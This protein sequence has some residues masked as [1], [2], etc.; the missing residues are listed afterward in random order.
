M[1][2]LS[3]KKGNEIGLT[4]HLDHT[5]ARVCSEALVLSTYKIA[6][7]LRHFEFDALGTGSLNVL[8]LFTTAQHF[9]KTRPST[10]LFYL[11]IYYS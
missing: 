10:I 3:L 5:R 11:F 1:A 7:L 8:Q 9:F 2:A 4:K 6:L